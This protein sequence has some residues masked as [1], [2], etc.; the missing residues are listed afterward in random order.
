M[1]EENYIGEDGLLY[2]GVCH[3]P[4]EALWENGE[5]IFGSD[6]QVHPPMA[7][8][9]F[10]VLCD[11]K[12]CPP[13]CNMFERICRSGGR[14]PLNNRLFSPINPFSLRVSFPTPRN[15]DKG[16]ISREE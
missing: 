5:A 10:C 1:S 4:K 8:C 13:F 2:C 7:D 6:R 3:E 15:Y 12:R 14:R 11:R 9:V 16:R